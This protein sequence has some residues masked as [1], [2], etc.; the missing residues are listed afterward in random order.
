MLK[1]RR[2]FTPEF[3]AQVVLD[4]LSGVQAPAEAC[5]QHA[6]SPNLLASWKARFLQRAASVFQADE[7][8]DKDQARLAE[9]EQLRATHAREGDPKTASMRLTGASIRNG[10]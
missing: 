5:R 9:L 7:P 8:R 3:Q 6:L 10:K 2:Q 1:K 4:V